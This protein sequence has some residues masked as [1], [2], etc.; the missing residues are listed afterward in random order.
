MYDGAIS[1]MDSANQLTLQTQ[2]DITLSGRV[3]RAFTLSG[4]S[5]VLQG[6]LVLA[7]DNLYMVYASYGPTV[8]TTVVTAFL[9]DFQ[10]TA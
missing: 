3:G 5:Y 9:A 7:G 4:S 2:S 6:E 1:G 10:L 8:D